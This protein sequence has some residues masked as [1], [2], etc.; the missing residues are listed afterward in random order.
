MNGS[1]DNGSGRERERSLRECRVW[2][3]L[4]D[5]EFI[6]PE[7]RENCN[8]KHKSE[9]LGLAFG[10]EGVESAALTLGTLRGLYLLGILSKAQYISSSS[11]PS[12]VV[13]P[14]SHYHGDLAAA[15]GEYLPPEKCTTKNLLKC[16]PT[17]HSYALCR[18]RS[19][20]VI[21]DELKKGYLRRN[22]ADPRGLCCGANVF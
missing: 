7:K 2:F 20:P 4:N 9:D 3:D 16:D 10:G 12:W 19:I 15:L 14:L 13:A 18:S 11:A 22:K 1:G 17:C 6:Y 21:I 5:L 8:F